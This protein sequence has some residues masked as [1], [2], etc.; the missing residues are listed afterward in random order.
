MWSI[1]L[2]QFF[3]FWDVTKLRGRGRERGSQHFGC[4]FKKMTG[5]QWIYQIKMQYMYLIPFWVFP[6]SYGENPPNCW[7]NKA[8]DTLCI[9][10]VLRITLAIFPV[11]T[12]DSV[13][14]AKAEISSLIL[15]QRGKKP[16][17]ISPPLTASKKWIWWN[18]LVIKYMLTWT[19]LLP[20][21]YWTLWNGI[22]DLKFQLRYSQWILPFKRDAFTKAIIFFML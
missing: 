16:Q 15:E 14:K 11:W 9:I 10:T 12:R 1:L 4:H 7:L 22:D 17:K 6:R 3:P 20:R 21:S 18:K 13:Y 2:S 5:Q 19:R 8:K